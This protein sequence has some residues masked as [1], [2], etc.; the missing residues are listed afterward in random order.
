[1]FNILRN[2]NYILGLFM[3]LILVTDCCC[4]FQNIFPLFPKSEC[5]D[6]AVYI[7]IQ[8]KDYIFQLSLQLEVTVSLSST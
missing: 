8:Y 5:P 6:L 1:M 2:K 4:L 3:Y 7:A